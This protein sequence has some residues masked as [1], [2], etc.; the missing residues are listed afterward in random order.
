VDLMTGAPSAGVS[1]AP[2]SGSWSSISDRDAKTDL[3]A[4]DPRAILERVAKLDIA[5]WRYKTQPPTIRHMGPMAQDF[6]AAFALGESDRQISTVD[7]DGV[8]LAAIQGLLL[9]MRQENAALR[10]EIEA[11]RQVI[12]AYESRR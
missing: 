10:A 7:A 3:A 11:L 1:L 9:L 6:H 4:V 2:G 8:A 5:T 12:A